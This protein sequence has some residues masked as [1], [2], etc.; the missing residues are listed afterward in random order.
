LFQSLTELHATEFDDDLEQLLFNFRLIVTIVSRTTYLPEIVVDMF[1]SRLD[2]VCVETVPEAPDDLGLLFLKVIY[3]CLLFSDSDRILTFIHSNAFQLLFQF[4]QHRVMVGWIVCEVCGAAMFP[5]I[6]R[7]I[8]QHRFFRFVVQQIGGTRGTAAALYMAGLAALLR[9]SPAVV[10]ELLGMA[11]LG[12]IAECVEGGPFE[13]KVHAALV[14]CE[15]GRWIGKEKGIG[16]WLQEHR[17]VSRVVELVGDMTDEAVRDYV[18]R[19]LL[20]V[21][22]RNRETLS[23]DDLEV[24]RRMECELADVIVAEVTGGEADG[25]EG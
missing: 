3:Y 9:E 25:D 6:R 19:V 5:E 10:G 4:T 11:E 2:C 16:E 1:M 23:E 15:L 18:L 13:V 21:V 14:M 22:S 12:A 8:E 7:A 24:L 17:V 20:A